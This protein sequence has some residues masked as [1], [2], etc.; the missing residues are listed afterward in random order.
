MIIR[1]V[2][3]DGSVGEARGGGSILSVVVVVVRFEVVK[4]V[5]CG[6]LRSDW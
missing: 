4:L 5:V 6:E 3:E 2:G 1:G